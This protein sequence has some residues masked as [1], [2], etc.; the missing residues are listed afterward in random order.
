[1]LPRFNN[2]QVGGLPGRPTAFGGSSSSQGTP[3]VITSPWGGQATIY[4]K[5]GKYYT[6]PQSI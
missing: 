5:A 4:C 1:M 2:N 3:V 6:D